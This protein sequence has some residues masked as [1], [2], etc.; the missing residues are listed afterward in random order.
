MNKIDHP[1]HKVVPVPRGAPSYTATGLEPIDCHVGKY[2]QS[3]VAQKADN[4]A[5]H[6]I[7]EHCK[8]TPGVNFPGDTAFPQSLMLVTLWLGTRE[9]AGVWL[10]GGN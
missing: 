4:I 8:H 3:T 1:E 5:R 6:W 10:H 2:R 7:W 9:F